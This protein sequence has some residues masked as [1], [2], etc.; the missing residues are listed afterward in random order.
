MRHG[1][2]LRKQFG[3]T[4]IKVAGKSGFTLRYR[5]GYR[6]AN[7][8]ATLKER[9][10]QA[11]WQPADASE[12]KVTAVFAEGYSGDKFKINIAASNLGLRQQDGLWMDNLDVFFVQREDVGLHAEVEGQT[13]NLRLTP[14]TYQDV[15]VAGVPFEHV[16]KLKQGTTSL[17][18]LVV[19]EN[20]G[21]LGS[22]TILAQALSGA[23]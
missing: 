16:V 17:R 13:L 23:S 21:R 9:F 12:I 6:S 7:E 14:A 8:P 19:D 1:G 11:I 5:T 18:V 15:M 3:L 22:L 10:K 2:S 20:S 4:N